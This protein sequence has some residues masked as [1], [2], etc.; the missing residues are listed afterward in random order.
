MYALKKY[1]VEPLHLP[2]RYI[3][4]YHTSPEWNINYFT[5]IENF[6]KLYKRIQNNWSLNDKKATSNGKTNL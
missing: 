6:L 5:M 3:L 4:S 2:A 1:S